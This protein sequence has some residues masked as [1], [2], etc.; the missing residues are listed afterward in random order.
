MGQQL[1]GDRRRHVIQ[2]CLGRV[3]AGIACDP[4]TTIAQMNER[5]FERVIEVDMLGVWRTVRAC[6]PQIIARQGHVLVTASLY[7]YF[8]GMVNAP[9]A[10]SKAGVEMFGRALRAE[11]AG[12]GATAGVLYPGWIAT[13]IAKVAFGG[14]ETATKLVSMAFP[15]PLNKAIL[16]ERVA[17]AVVEG[18][19]RRNAR[20]TVPSR[21]IPISLLRGVVNVLSD[22]MLDHNTK[23]QALTRQLEQESS[24]R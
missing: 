18:I 10:M 13:P 16:P 12:T 17:T 4:P 6:L 5:T 11:L 14:N 24:K 7:S 15:W 19:Q 2:P 1:D 20:I 8:N 22:K 3:I 23:I 21:W 9:Y